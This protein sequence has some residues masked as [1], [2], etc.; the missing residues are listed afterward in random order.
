MRSSMRVRSASI[1]T[2][3]R[4]LVGD[5]GDVLVGEAT[6][7]MLLRCVLQAGDGDEQVFGARVAHYSEDFLFNRWPDAREPTI[8]YIP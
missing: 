8:T 7:E 3:T 2:V 1:E 6:L 4:D 5:F